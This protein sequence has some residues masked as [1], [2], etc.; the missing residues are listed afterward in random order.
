MQRRRVVVR[1]RVQGVG[2]RWSA[3]DEA[4]RLGLA[5]WVENR[6]D[7]TVEAVVEGEESAVEAMLAWLRHGPRTARVTGVDV[8][9]EQPEGLHG[10]GVRR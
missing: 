8:Q 3:T 2:F 6:D 7:G 1:G 4:E 10:F 5:G 9:E